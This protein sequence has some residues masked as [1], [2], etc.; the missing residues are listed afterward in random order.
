MLTACALAC[1]HSAFALYHP[2]SIGDFREADGIIHMVMCMN[3]A[4]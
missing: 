1:L 4:S 2:V 3:A